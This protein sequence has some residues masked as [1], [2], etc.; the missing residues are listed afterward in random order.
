MA[1]GEHPL[2]ESRKGVWRPRTLAE[3][4]QLKR[5]LGGQAAVVSG[6]TLLRTQWEA[7]TALMPAHLISLEGIPDLYVCEAGETGIR[8][9]AGVT[10]EACLRGADLP[11]LLK[12]AC[13]RIAAPSIRRLG[14]IGGNVMSGLGD[15]L[16]ALAVTDAELVWYDGS[17]TA[18][19]PV[20]AWLE[21]RRT[22]GASAKETRLLKAIRWTRK[23][24]DEGVYGCYE[25]V[26]RRE[27][28][29]PSV[30][31][32]AGRFRLD[33]AG[34]LR[35]VRL[36]AGSA[37]STAY[38][39]AA[40]ESLL[41]GSVWSAGLARSL[42]QAVKDGFDGGDDAFATAAYRK[43]VA[44]HLLTAFLEERASCR[45]DLRKER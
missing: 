1:V 29:C 45:E 16:P 32:V 33:A 23:A 18:V 4:W 40:A 43:R 6:G 35:D 20:G 12:E 10:L 11:A 8:I 27:A 5:T 15:S 42:H 13:R 36:A 14:T 17:G 28:F 19:E 41:E 7:G 9:G 24:E 2:P 26:G 37:A 31:T 39:L 44:A 3:A 38:R 22:A 34:R 25:K 21:R 30:V